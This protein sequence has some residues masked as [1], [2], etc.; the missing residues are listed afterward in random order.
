MPVPAGGGGTT[1]LY[2]YTDRDTV[3]SALGKTT[4]DD[5]DDLIDAA[6][7]AASRQIDQR[8]GRYFYADDAASA[9]T[10]RA[11]GRLTMDG[12]D[13][14]LEVDDFAS[15][16]SIVVETSYGVAGTWST[17]STYELGPDNADAVWRPWTQIRGSAGWVIQ[18][19]KVRVT[20]Q[21]GWPAIPDEITQAAT[22]LAARLYR[23]KDSPQGVIASADWGS[24]RVSRTDP[25]VEALIGPFVIPAFA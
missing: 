3:K 20:A 17:V 19:G 1:A 22:L 10:F 15:D 2:T 25:D 21:W 23:R 9:R 6:I 11:R 4:A 16:D 24:V 14:V 12:C 13:W 18:H 8:C 7:A 5:R